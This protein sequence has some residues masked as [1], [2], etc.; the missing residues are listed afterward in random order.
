LKRIQ[1]DIGDAPPDDAI[2]PMPDADRLTKHRR[3]LDDGSFAKALALSI[4][5]SPPIPPPAVQER[6]ERIIERLR[7]L[8]RRCGDLAERRKFE[9][10]IGLRGLQAS[11]AFIIAGIVGVISAVTPAIFLLP[12][13]GGIAMGA[14]GYYAGQ[15]LSKEAKLYKDMEERCTKLLEMCHA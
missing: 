4:P 12:I 5:T 6:A 14:M 7:S 15:Q 1:I 3:V 8:R 2:Q 9:S 11:P 13:A 10:D